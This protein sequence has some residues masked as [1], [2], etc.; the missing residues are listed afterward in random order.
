MK[1]KAM[2]SRFS[3]SLG[4][5]ADSAPLELIPWEQSLFPEAA[6]RP[7]LPSWVLVDGHLSP[8][9]QCPHLLLCFVPFRSCPKILPSPSG[10]S[11]RPSASPP[12]SATR[13]LCWP[14][15]GGRTPTG[16]RANTGGQRAAHPTVG[17]TAMSLSRSHPAH[18]TNGSQTALI[19]PKTIENPP[20]LGGCL[21]AADAGA[22]WGTGCLWEHPRR[23][24]RF[25]WA[26][27]LLCLPESTVHY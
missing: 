3:C 21:M 2:W 14:T 7:L 27:E 25:P 18:R 9:S 6:R 26:S 10:R 16:K 20:S 13:T 15:G 19:L 22:Q 1:V 4:S 17:A 8:A 23:G 24:R 5:G 11:H 12:S